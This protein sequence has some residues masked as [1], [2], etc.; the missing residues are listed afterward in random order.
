MCKELGPLNGLILQVVASHHYLSSIS[1][2]TKDIHSFDNT[3][4]MWENKKSIAQGRKKLTILLVSELTAILF[5]TTRR[6]IKNLVKKQWISYSKEKGI[7]YNSE[8]ELN[9]ESYIYSSEE[10]EE[11]S[12]T[13]READSACTS[14]LETLGAGNESLLKLFMRAAGCLILISFPRC[15]NVNLCMPSSLGLPAGTC[16]PVKKRSCSL[17]E[18]VLR[19]LA[20]DSDGLEER[21]GG[22]ERGSGS[23]FGESSNTDRSSRS[24]PGRSTCRYLSLYT[25]SGFVGAGTLLIIGVPLPS[26]TIKICKI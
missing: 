21:A 18:L 13:T 23:S 7:L 3:L 16:S 25:S 17:L 11:S 22:P 10:E 26:S 6:K 14:C 24:S 2:T 5:E 4:K 15:W 12:N 8:S 20:G 9:E 1:E 19:G